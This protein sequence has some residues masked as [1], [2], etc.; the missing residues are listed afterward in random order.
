MPII[1]NSKARK[2]RKE[3]RCDLCLETIRK[4][5]VYDWTKTIQDGMIYDLS[6][7]RSAAFCVI[8]YG[9]TH[10]PTTMGWMQIRLQSITKLILS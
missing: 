7:I 3:H 8:S 5:E 10:K 4:G 9:I 2:E 1:L 6:A